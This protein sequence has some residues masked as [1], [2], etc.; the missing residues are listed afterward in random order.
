[1]TTT[2]PEW[3][4]R[5]RRI[6]RI[7]ERMMELKNAGEVPGSIHLCNGQ[8]AIPVAFCSVL[9]ERD[10]VS[11]TYRG[12][13]W[14][15]AR[16]TDPAALYGEVMGK[17]GGTNGG[18]AASPFLSDPSIGFLGENSIVGAGVPVALGAA[19]SALHRGDGGVAVVSIGDGALN[20]GNAHEALNMAAVLKAPLVVVVENNVYSEMSP[21]ADM[22]AID[23]LAERGAAY[24]IP[25]RRV[26]GNDIDAV[27]AVAEEVVA[28]ARRGE[29][30][31]LVEC[32]TQRLVG[33]YSG[34]AQQYRPKGEIAAAREVEPL[35]RLRA[36]HPELADEF[37]RVDVEVDAE[38]E[39]AIATAQAMP[40]PDPSTVKDHIH[41]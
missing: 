30:P 8:E 5:M 40:T 27:L 12:H 38:V 41:V 36:A 11:A 10:Q 28:A 26:D 31:Q 23:T 34:D 6:R 25:A 35:V 22:V 17:A 3:Y 21:I 14:A 15:L 2:P 16:G 20:Q 32:L 24:G 18:R 29:G 19:L 33:H 7:E 1:M 9:D 4:R 13:G 39:A 37:D